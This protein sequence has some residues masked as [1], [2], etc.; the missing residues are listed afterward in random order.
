[1]NPNGVSVDTI[2]RMLIEEHL[3]AYR[4]VV[5]WTGQTSKK[6][7]IFASRPDKQMEK[8]IVH[9]RKLDERW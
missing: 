4:A 2:E 8:N 3:N 9:K 6:A 1:L 7:L 5:R